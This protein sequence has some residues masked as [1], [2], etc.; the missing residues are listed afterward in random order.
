M[1]STLN[2]T[3]NATHNLTNLATITP[4][5]TPTPMEGLVYING[6]LQKVPVVAGTPFPQPNSSGLSLTN[7]AGWSNFAD[8]PATTLMKGILT[9]IAFLVVFAIIVYLEQ[10]I[11]NWL[12]ILKSRRE[13]D[14]KEKERERLNRA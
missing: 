13:K 10:I 2:A 8:W 7:L 3:I 1:N 9:L 5:P 4:M 6:A 11:K 14:R 12:A